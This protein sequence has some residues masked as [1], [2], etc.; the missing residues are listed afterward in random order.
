MA[1]IPAKYVPLNMSDK[2]K[3]KDILQ[4]KR[5]SDSEFNGH[6][7]QR[8]WQKKN[9]QTRKPQTNK[10]Y[11]WQDPPEAGHRPEKILTERG[12]I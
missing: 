8:Q 5:Y 6:E 11:A 4:N 1:T 10:K 12:K 3:L 7:N 9:H 2:P